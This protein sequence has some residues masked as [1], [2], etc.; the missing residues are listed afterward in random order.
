MRGAK[1]NPE[2]NV[3]PLSGLTPGF[4]RHIFGIL[5]FRKEEPTK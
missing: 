4:L 1:E 5:D 3:N 2:V